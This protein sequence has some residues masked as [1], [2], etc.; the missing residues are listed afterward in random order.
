M[1]PPMTSTRLLAAALSVWV[2]AAPLSALAGDEYPRRTIRIVVPVP[3]GGTADAVPRLVAEKLAERFQQTVLI[4]NRPGAALNIGAASVAHAAPDGYTLLATPPGPLI[5]S[6]FLYEDLTFDPTSLI[7]VTILGEVP[8]VLVTRPSFP[9]NSIA[10]LRDYAKSQPVKLTFGS[11][12]NGSP[13]HLA[14]ELFASKA[15][16]DLVHVPYKGMTAALNDVLGGHVD[17]LFHDLASVLPLL[18]ARQIKALGISSASRDAKL[19]EVPIIAEVYPDFVLTTWYAIAAPP[20][21]SSAI[22]SK[23][24]GAISDIVQSPEVANR[25]ATFGMTPVGR[26]PAET[27]QFIDAERTHWHSIMVAAKVVRP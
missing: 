2:S 16:I 3:P 19:P 21:T 9:P 8:F 6:Q 24:A 4:E 27:A 22:T 23:L 14:A 18:Q 15:G 20:H 5:T 7:P 10:E 13:P 25:L 12:G 26:R 17:M 11:T 1:K